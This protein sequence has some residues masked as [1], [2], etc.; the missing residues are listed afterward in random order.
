MHKQ[1]K[2]DLIFG[3]SEEDK[4]YKYLINIYPNLKRCKKNDIYDF[5]DDTQKLYIELK[6]RRCCKSTYDST[7][8]PLNKIKWANQKIDKYKFIFLFN[9]YDGL[10]KYDYTGDDKS[11]S[12]RNGGR[13]DR[14]I[15]EFKIYSYI[16]TK[17][18]K[19]I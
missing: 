2:E 13:Q 16:P 1:H 6:S 11:Y 10:Y 15:K 17:F 5:Y 14:G 12:L 3:L 18:L 8:F 19:K 9:F 7:M 4:V